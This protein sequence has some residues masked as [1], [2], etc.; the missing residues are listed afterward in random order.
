MV[1]VKIRNFSTCLHQ[2][3]LFG[4]VTSPDQGICDRLLAITPAIGITN[5]DI[6]KKLD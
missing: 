2:P 5:I 4:Y 6:K 1:N 3:A